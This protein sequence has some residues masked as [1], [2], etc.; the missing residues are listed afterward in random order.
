MVIHSGKSDIGEYGDFVAEFDWLVGQ[1]INSLKE[2]GLLE[3]TLVI[4]TSDN[5]AWAADD[6]YYNGKRAPD[7]LNETFRAI[8]DAGHFS[9][10]LYQGNKGRLFEGGHRIPLIISW[11]AEIKHPG[12]NFSFVKFYIPFLCIYV[13]C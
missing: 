11:P 8:R 5:G 12:S 2:S 6:T 10:L 4:V 3:N 7:N 13:Q 9:N 1:V